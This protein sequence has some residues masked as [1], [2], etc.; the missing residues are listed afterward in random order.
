M[1]TTTQLREIQKRA[2]GMCDRAGIVLTPTEIENIE[3]V[4]EGLNDV[5]GTG[6]QIVT[7]VNTER[8]CA[9]ELILFPRQTCP[10]HAHP[11]VGGTIGKEE[12][13]RC[14]WGTVYLYVPGE[15]VPNPKAVPPKGTEDYY[16]SWHELVLPPGGQYTIL[17]A[18][19]HWFQAGGEGAIIS[20]FS[21]MSMD[22]TD[23]FTNPHIR[24][25]T[26]IVEG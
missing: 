7:Y 25:I 14:R 23:V 21:T 22:E 17:P 1:I 6:L 24:R 5:F 15:S 12:T 10:E 18:T 9:K 8:V 16:T 4:D 11:A 3:V 2:A 19:L 20:E 13:F 26:E